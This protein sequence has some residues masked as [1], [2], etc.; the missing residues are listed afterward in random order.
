VSSSPKLKF[1]GIDTPGAMQSYWTVPAHTL[2]HLPA[3][4]P[5]HRA[6]LVEW[7]SVA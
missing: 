1:M 6:A 7:V 3:V 4:L 5:F 2:H